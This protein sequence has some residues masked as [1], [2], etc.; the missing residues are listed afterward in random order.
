M[1]NILRSTL[2]TFALIA[3]VLTAT[4]MPAKADGASSTRTILESIAAVALIAT[5]VNVQ[6]KN[7]VANTVEGYLNDG[8]TVYQDGHVMDRNGQS[9]YPSQYG[10]AVSC[11]GSNCYLSAANNAGYN[12]GNNSGNNGYQRGG[13]RHH[14]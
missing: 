12:A 9:Y 4:A 8:S 14:G 7:A 1:K 3:T 13:R 11:N 5:V 2:A 6:H 10:Q